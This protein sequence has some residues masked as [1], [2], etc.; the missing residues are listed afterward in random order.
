[1]DRFALLLL[2]LVMITIGFVLAAITAG[3]ALMFLTKI[4]TPH[5]ANQLS[6]SGLDVGLVIGAFA[7]A[8]LAGYVAFFPAMLIILYGEF[9]R[10]RDWL[11]Y[12][13]SGGAIA[14]A[15]PL[16]LLLIR[17]TRRQPDFEFTLLCLASGMISGIVYWFISGRNAGNWLPDDKQHQTV[18][19]PQSEKS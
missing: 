17:S 18:S 1:M 9:T 10:R 3:I 8:S 12:A 2:R 19:A 11:F 16:I 14:A 6:Q 13:L 5:E 7:L 4:L 15:A